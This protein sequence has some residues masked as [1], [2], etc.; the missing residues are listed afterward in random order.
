MGLASPRPLRFHL[1]MI[2]K[3]EKSPECLE[4]FATWPVHEPWDRRGS[5]RQLRARMPCPGGQNEQT[6]SPS[7]HSRPNSW[8]K[9]VRFLSVFSRISPEQTSCLQLMQGAPCFPPHDLG[10][11]QMWFCWGCELRVPCVTLSSTIRPVRCLTQTFV[12]RLLHIFCTQW[13]RR[14]ELHA[15]GAGRRWTR[16]HTFRHLEQWFVTRTLMALV[17]R[18]TA[19]IDQGILTLLEEA[20]HLHFIPRS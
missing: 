14:W 8:L 12:Q 17:Q 4:C 15:R 9:P 18:L 2:F 7:Q 5:V 6:Q 20:V 10:V 16:S 11:L 1:K 3:R 13:E 19:N